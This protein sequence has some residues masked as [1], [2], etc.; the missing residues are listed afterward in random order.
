MTPKK[1]T[2]P[3]TEN[4]TQENHI[5]GKI[6]LGKVT[7]FRIHLGSGK[8]N[9]QVAFLAFFSQNTSYFEGAFLKKSQTASEGLGH[10]QPSR[11]K[12]ND[13]EEFLKD[14]LSSH[15]HS[16]PCHPIT[17]HIDS[18]LLTNQTTQRLQPKADERT[19]V[20]STDD[21][22]TITGHRRRR[23]DSKEP[24]T[25]RQRTGDEKP[26]TLMTPT[27][28]TKSQPTISG[29]TNVARQLDVPVPMGVLWD[30]CSFNACLTVKTVVKLVKQRV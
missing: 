24:K 20:A 14:L 29:R 18:Y 6:R 28:T 1:N 8:C 4:K 23:T 30:V 16:S 15:R 5:S 27:P 9:L 3:G 10:R 17:S 25:K 12:D 26:T 19:A 22:K 7:F 11:R 13:E 21:E 2:F